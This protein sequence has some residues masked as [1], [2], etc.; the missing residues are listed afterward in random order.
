MINTKLRN[1]IKKYLE[2]KKV[3]LI[4]GASED[5]EVNLMLKIIAPYV[6][7][8][9]FTKSNHPRALKISKLEKIAKY[10]NLYNY[11]KCEIEKLV[12]LILR[13]SNENNVFIAT[14]SIF[15][16]GAIKELIAYREI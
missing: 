5:K 3:I 11:S 2:K 13:K 9:I 1:T 15:V 4:F 7:Y 10:L 6:D 12:P 16:A 8:F 14:G